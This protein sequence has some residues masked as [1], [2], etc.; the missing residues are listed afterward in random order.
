M[1][2]KTIK[3]L[4]A[5]GLAAMTFSLSSC[6]DS[7]SSSSAE[8]K[9]DKVYLEDAKSD[10][11]DREVTFARLGQLLRLQGSGFKGVT[12]IT[13]NGYETYFNNALMTDNN[14]WVTLNSN[15]PITDADADERNTIKL[16]KGDTYYSYAFEIRSA[17]PAVSYL[18]NTLPTAGETVIVY[19]S[20]LHETNKVTLPSGTEITSGIDNGEDGT[21]YSFIMPSGE[22]VSGSITS[23]GANGTAMTPPYFLDFNCYI[24]DFDGTGALGS[25]SATYSTDDLVDDPLNSGRGKV[26]MIVP[27][28]VL[29]EGGIE[30]GAKSSLWATAGND[31]ADDDWSRMYTYIPATTDLS[32]V[33]LQFD[34]YCPDAW[35]GTGQLEFS[36]QNNLSSYGWGSTETT[37]TTNVKYPTAYVWVP[38]M[39]R[40]TGDTLSFSTDGWETVTIPLTDFGKY[41]DDGGSHTFKEVV[42]DRNNASYKN[43]VFLLVNTDLVFDEDN[44]VTFVSSTFNKKI[45]IDNLRIV[46]TTSIT[47]SDFDD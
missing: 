36:L 6:S 27:Q 14:I 1:K 4:F 11:P 31:N 28:S 16:Y 22:T 45:Y 29:D 8:A 46:N 30:S 39:D 35:N 3:Y 15:T 38:W 33:A 44:N 42:E 13:V 41:S 37:Y 23:T 32:N 9:I 17:S 34:V 19:G 18:S 25:W 47:V 21:W 24:T 10:V 43:L 2:M 5:I 26:C 40:S 7:E 20:S 12:K